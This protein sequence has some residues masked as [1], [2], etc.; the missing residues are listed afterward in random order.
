MGKMF[1]IMSDAHSKWLEIHMTTLTSSSTTINLMRKSFATLGLPE[2]IVSDNSTTFTSEEFSQF[3]QKNGV[4]HVRTPPYH[5]ASNGLA[6]RAVQTFKEGMKKMQ[7][8]SVE[9][10]LL[11]FLFKY[12][13][14]PH[15]STGVSPAELMFGRKLRSHLDCLQ[16]HL[17]EKVEDSQNRQKIGHDSRAKSREF[18]VDE[19]VYAKN[20]GS[21]LP[22]LPGKVVKKL[23]T[24]MY[25]VLLENGQKVRKHADQLKHRMVESPVEK[26]PDEVAVDLPLSTEVSITPDNSEAT[27]PDD[28]VPDQDSEQS[29]SSARVGSGPTSPQ[30]PPQPE[31][32][33]SSRTKNQPDRYGYRND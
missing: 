20:Y 3:L 4:R 29:T 19:L 8:G 26:T 33:Q 27:G 10:K 25:R 24:V 2:V 22:W 16:P 21:G 17:H 9:T 12:R 32:R 28:P 18:R 5:P 7:E 13:I 30:Q 6:E 1:L 15:S 23:G 11:R 31:R 14:T